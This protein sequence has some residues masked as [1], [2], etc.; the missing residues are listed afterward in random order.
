M[1]VCQFREEREGWDIKKKEGQIGGDVGSSSPSGPWTAGG[2]EVS[3]ESCL[4]RRVHS[5]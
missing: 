2:C 1:S 3:S 5:G 4:E